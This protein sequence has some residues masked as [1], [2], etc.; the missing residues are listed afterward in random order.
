MVG[1]TS[2]ATIHVSNPRLDKLSSAVIRGVAPEQGPRMFEFCVPDDA[3]FSISPHVGVVNPGEVSACMC[4][5]EMFTN[6]TQCLTLLEAE[7]ES[8]LQSLH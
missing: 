7:S 3:P 1:T 6:V 5:T 4:P 8:L 2:E